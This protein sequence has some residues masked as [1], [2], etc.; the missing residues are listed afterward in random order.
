[1]TP[2]YKKKA[3]KKRGTEYY[4]I[5]ER[6]LEWKL[7]GGG[8]GARSRFFG[9]RGGV[10]SGLAILL[11]L[12]PQPTLLSKYFRPPETAGVVP[13]RAMTFGDPCFV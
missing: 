3:K 7:G 11:Q 6:G 1:M 2:C 5:G 13:N 4:E 8:R 10:R 9:F 12:K